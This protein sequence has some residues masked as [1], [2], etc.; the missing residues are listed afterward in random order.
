MGTE[1]S[2]PGKWFALRRP[3]AARWVE[4]HSEIRQFCCQCDSAAQRS[5]R[6]PARNPASI[7]AA[8][9]LRWALGKGLARAAGEPPAKLRANLER[10]VCYGPQKT[11]LLPQKRPP[12]A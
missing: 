12:A 5:T 10:L 9:P 6:A 4:E 3:F 2:V 7:R 1:L 8:Q 11:E